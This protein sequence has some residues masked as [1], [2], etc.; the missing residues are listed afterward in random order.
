M[1]KRPP[2]PAPVAV[3]ATVAETKAAPAEIVPAEAVAET[4]PPEVVP[5]DAVAQNDSS[6]ATAIAAEPV[7]EA[8]TGD[9]ADI[10][11]DTQPAAELGAASAATLLP[12]VAFSTTTAE[13]DSAAA[14][15]GTDL[16]VSDDVVTAATEAPQEPAATPINAGGESTASEEAAAIHADAAP[17][18]P[19]AATAPELVEVWRPGGRPDERR[20]RHD[21]KRHND[22]QTVSIQ[23]AATPAT[24]DTGETAKPEHHGHRRR[25]RNNEF[26]K[27]RTDASAGPAP[28]S[29]VVAPRDVRDDKDRPPRDRFQGKG[30]DRDKGKFDKGKFQGKPRGE[31]EDRSSGASHR[32][33]AS[34]A[35]PRDR[36]RPADPN[37]P[38]AKLA[39]LKDQLTAN[40]KDQR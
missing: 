16:S 39:A 23:P 34:S 22:R 2:L 30:R 1:E 33:Y 31:R 20:S 28:D 27:P 14:Q 11:S 35:A 17:V 40:R 6:T 38:F 4:A 5:T 24:G 8:K 25:D 26:R 36:D 13:Q 19:E 10:D 7:A 29:P 12:D 3:E 18:P 9:V 32:Q 37:S 21:R 15:E